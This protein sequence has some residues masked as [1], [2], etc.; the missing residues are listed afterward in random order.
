MKK[1]LFIYF[2]LLL[3]MMPVSVFAAA[4][5]EGREFWVALTIA[6]APGDKNTNFEPYICVSSKSRKGTV[7]VTNPQTNFVRT[8]QIPTGTGWLEIKDI[9]VSAWYPYANGER[10]Q[11]KASGRTFQTGLMVTSTEDVSV[12]AA[13]RYEFAFDASNILPLTALQSE[14]IIQDYP[15]YANIDDDSSELT[16]SFSNFC[17]LATENNTEVEITPRAKTYDGKVAGSTFKVTLNA[18]QVYYVVSEQSTDNGDKNSDDSDKKSLSGSYVRALN[19]KKVAVFN[20]DICTRVPNGVSARDINYEQAMPIDYWGTE[21][22]IT[23]SLEKDANRFRITAQEDGTVINIDGFPF[24]T[25]NAR[26]TCEIE[27]AGGAPEK[28]FDLDT[29][30]QMIQDVAYI[31]TSCPCAVYNY[32]TGNQYKRK[33]NSEIII[34]KHGDPSMTWVSPLEQNLN[35]ITFGVM[36]TDKTTHHFVNIVTETANVGNLELREVAAGQFSNNMLSAADFQPVAANPGYSYARKALS[37]NKNTTYNLKSSQS[38]FIAHVYGNGKNESYAYSAGSSAVKRGLQLGNQVFS[39]ESVSDITYCVGDPIHFNA[40]VGTDVI[41]NATWDMGDGK[42]FHDGRIEFDYAYDS[43]GWYDIV[44]NVAAHKV[45]PETSYPV[46]QVSVRIHV[47]IPDTVRRNFFICEGESFEYGGTTYTEATVDTAYFNCDSVVIFRLEVGKKTSFEMDSVAH[48]SCYWNGQ[49]Y[50]A[51][52]DYQWVGTNA[53]GCDSIVT[54]HLHILTC[55][56]MDIHSPAISFCGDEPFVI[57]PYDYKKGDIGTA[58]LYVDGKEYAV[59]MAE[60][61]C[62]VDMQPFKPGKYTNARIVVSDPVCEQTLEFPVT[63]EVRYPVSVFAQKWDN[64]LAVY[65]KDYNGGYEFSAFQWYKNGEPIPGATGSWYHSDTPLSPDDTYSVLLTTTDGRT[66]LSCEK[67]AVDKSA[68]VAVSVSPN[69]VAPGEAVT[70]KT[71]ASGN[72]LLYNALGVKE[73]QTAVTDG[74]MLRMPQ[75][76]GVYVLQLQL[77]DG[78]THSFRLIVR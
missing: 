39:N 57:F 45:C 15:P 71:D 27:L 17:I 36:N 62:I 37:I 41:D 2:A 55:L 31:Q 3:M 35:E 48:D 78:T 64:V 5:T 63:F 42:K 76:T 19:G 51:S 9:P 4:G 12:F 28:G 75:R 25:L 24:T 74:A 58:V 73:M 65:N 38:G 26:E 10:E 59:E 8:Y 16:T 20:G 30:C 44:A 18:G 1:R 22:I 61:E 77:E 66:V 43:P 34:D 70:V 72:A 52:G 23:R 50:Y 53:A 11:Q 54:I 68:G 33:Q 32:D 14:Y 56:D 60:G 46:E 7:T 21:F 67:N 6:R 69:M 29:R 49:W 13:I 40:Q 47:V